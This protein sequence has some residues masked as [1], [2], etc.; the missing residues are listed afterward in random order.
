MQAER[1]WVMGGRM[2]GH[3]AIVVATSL[4]P[5]TDSTIDA[6]PPFLPYLSQVP[7]RRFAGDICVFL[8]LQATTGKGGWWGCGTE[9]RKGGGGVEMLNPPHVSFLL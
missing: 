7:R 9:G 1:E 2:V 6:P 5:P 8:Y 3:I 4:P